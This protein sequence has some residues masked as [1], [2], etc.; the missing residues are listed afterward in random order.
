M[1]PLEPVAK[2]NTHHG[3]NVFSIPRHVGSGRIYI[4]G[5]ASV[6][7]ADPGVSEW[8]TIAYDDTQ[9]KT[10]SS[11]CCNGEIRQNW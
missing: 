10:L 5:A 6:V 8:R 1:H 2:R 4:H 11:T 3:G 7:L 9:P